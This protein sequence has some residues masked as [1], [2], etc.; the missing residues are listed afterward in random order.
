MNIRHRRLSF[1]TN[2]KIIVAVTFIAMTLYYALETTKIER[3]N[4][5][6]NSMMEDIKE[7]I[8]MSTY[9]SLKKGNMEQF[10]RQMVE[11]GKS[12]GILEYSL[13]D[14][15]GLVHYSSD[16][17]KKNHTDPLVMGLE[18]QKTKIDGD[19][20]T[21]Y[22]PVITVQYCSRCH[23][24][25]SLD[26][27]NSYY[28]LTLDRAAVSEVSRLSWYHNLFIFF[29]GTLFLAFIYLLF[30]IVERRKHEE[31]LLLS[32]SVFDNTVE[33]I[34]ITDAKNTIQKVNAA[35]TEITQFSAEE[36]IGKTIHILNP[37]GSDTDVHIAM[38]KGLKDDGLWCGEMWNRRQSGEIF[39]TWLSV[40][41]VKNIH[42]DIINFVSLFHD[43][44]DLKETQD[45]LKYQ[46]YHDALTGLP[47]RKLFLD[48]LEMAIAHAQR[49]KEGVAVIFIDLDNFKNINDR[50]G[51][52]TGD[53]LLKDVAQRLT[54]SC[55]DIDTVARL[56]GDEFTVILPSMESPEMVAPVVARI[57]SA[58]EAPLVTAEG[59][60]YT[61][62]SIG[63][64]MFPQDGDTIDA[65][66]KNADLA[67]YRAKQHGKGTYV[68]YTEA[69]TSSALHRIELEN[70]LKQALHKEEFVL[71]Y[72]PVVNI[73]TGRIT[74]CEA[75]IRW[76]RVPGEF[77]S[78]AEFIPL[79]E[80]TDL[81]Y[82]LGDWVMTTACQ[83][84]KR[85]HDA[86]YVDLS[87][88]VNF[89]SKKFQEDNLADKI[90][91]L[92]EKYDL[93]P[94]ALHVELTELTVMGNLN[95]VKKN[96]QELH[97]AGVVI[98]LDDFGTGYSALSYLQ[99][100]PLDIIKIDRSFVH[101]LVENK[102][103]QS[104]ARAILN[105]CSDLGMGVIAEGIENEQQL[106]FFRKHNC[107]EYQGFFF[108]KPLDADA[109]TA[110]L[111]Q[112]QRGSAE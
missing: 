107:P 20:I 63:I 84:I 44:T 4:L 89:S 108:S 96:M 24:S 27:V 71:H 76:Q 39:P 22:F 9:G 69:M 37:D 60:L 70:G 34:A 45:R 57:L 80:Q 91:H 102:R 79:T 93:R 8:F 61:G 36:A 18:K 103:D 62:G 11:I 64:T 43:I 19:N 15:N 68:F 17:A 99:Q 49:Y 59:D 29:G 92:F 85:W 21:Y 110:L 1:S 2:F 25:W 6:L 40:S 16:P 109:F 101:D 32:A 105:L 111:K 13:L 54:T 90:V 3:I 106:D 73:A 10:N 53:L 12:H 50:Y 31:Q 66:I 94:D 67:M 75:L 58:L 7:Q 78:P 112:H 86:G 30:D 95:S 41:V 38:R 56:G 46:A 55:R 82:P 104:V 52:Q 83:Q 77:T 81:V 47:N 87:V 26:S 100:F 5:S 88:A 33:G 23:M 35:F 28:K 51:H 14:A 97:D 72:Q 65:L 98:A 48:R 74:G 42:G